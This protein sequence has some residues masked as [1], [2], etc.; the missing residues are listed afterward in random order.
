LPTK[1]I[2]EF[3]RHIEKLLHSTITDAPVSLVEYRKS[4]SNLEARLAL[5]GKADDPKAVPLKPIQWYLALSQNV[6]AIRDKKGNWHLRTLQYS[7]R[8]QDGQGLDS[9]WFFRFEYK[10]REV[11]DR[12]HPRHHLHLP[13]S[14]DCGSRNVNLAKV[15]IPT[16]WVTIE[17]LLRFLISE[18]GVKTK[19][20]NWDSI[21]RKSEEKLWEWTQ[22]SV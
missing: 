19:S 10:S 17:E 14:L 21:L 2:T 9:R 13:A 20:K 4:V 1:V 16:G 7:Y 11:L 6:A 5:G 8:L 15:H 22:Q 3:H 18:L 12:L